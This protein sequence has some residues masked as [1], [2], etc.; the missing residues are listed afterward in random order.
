VLKFSRQRSL[1]RKTFP[2]GWSHEGDP[3]RVEKNPIRRAG[4]IQPI[5]G[6]RVPDARKMHPDL[7]RAA[8]ADAD[9]KISMV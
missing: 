3:V 9:F 5:P 4:A 1:Y 2:R 7:V 6:H 8:R